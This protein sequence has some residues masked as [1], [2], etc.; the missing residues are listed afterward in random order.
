MGD[1]TMVRSIPIAEAERG[2]DFVRALPG[3]F[4]DKAAHGM[5]DGLRDP[6]RILLVGRDCA[7]ASEAAASVLVQRVLSRRGTILRLRSCPAPFQAAIVSQAQAAGL[8][9]RVEV[10]LPSIHPAPPPPMPRMTATH[11]DEG[12]RLIRLD[13]LDDAHRCP[14]V[15]EGMRCLHARGPRDEFNRPRDD[16]WHLGVNDKGERVEWL[17][18][19]QWRSYR[20]PRFT[21]TG[22]T[23]DAF[24]WLGLA[25]LSVILVVLGAFSGGLEPVERVITGVT[26][27]FLVLATVRYNALMCYI[28]QQ[29]RP[30]PIGQQPW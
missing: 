29:A 28:D 17:Y 26:G 20:S 11:D 5:A 13:Q 8:L 14:R 10:V 16:H 23:L 18:H 6:G 15:F 21:A 2:V 24:I 22:M 25:A 3:L 4:G 1:P 19:T 12:R 7:S 9:D 30:E 27:G